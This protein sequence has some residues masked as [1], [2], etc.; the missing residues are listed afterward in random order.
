MKNLDTKKGG[1]DTAAE[2]NE[3]RK[4]VYELYFE[5][6]MSARKIAELLGK[7]RNTINE[8]IKFFNEQLVLEL[9]EVDYLSSFMKQV[10]RL[11]SQRC[12]LSDQLEKQENISA[13]LAIE[14]QLFSI[15]GKLLLMYENVPKIKPYSRK[16]PVPEEK[17]KEFTRN[18]VLTEPMEIYEIEEV[19]QKFIQ[20][21]KCDFST[22][23]EFAEDMEIIGL[24]ACGDDLDYDMICFAKIRGYLS[25]S[26]IKMINEKLQEQK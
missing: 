12:R 23:V 9:T 6:G 22:A 3:R 5:K 7:S 13:I 25:E 15:D 17:I 24:S 20:F 2:Q 18:L 26:E 8:D 10:N 19:H 21:F 4:K 14:K 1:P 11:E 16:P